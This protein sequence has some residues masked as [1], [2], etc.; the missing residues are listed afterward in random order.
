MKSASFSK[1]I[2][3]NERVGET[4]KECLWHS[5]VISAFKGFEAFYFQSDYFTPTICVFGSSRLRLLTTVTTDWA[6]LM[7]AM[8][9]A[10]SL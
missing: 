1:E 4:K 8:P 10:V 5:Y 7:K 3:Q 9:V 6:R 2:S